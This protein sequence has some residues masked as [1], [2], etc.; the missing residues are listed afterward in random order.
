MSK[1]LVAQNVT[2]LLGDGDQQVK[3]LESQRMLMPEVWDSKPEY[4]LFGPR[5]Q[6]VLQGKASS[7][8]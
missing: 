1:S 2:L 8:P 6:V 4:S 7:G 5:E 3:A